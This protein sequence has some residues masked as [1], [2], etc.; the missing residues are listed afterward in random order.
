MESLSFLAPI[1]FIFG[2]AGFAE[3]SRLKKDVAELKAEVE[4]LKNK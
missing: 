1:A 3:A 2:L 4:K